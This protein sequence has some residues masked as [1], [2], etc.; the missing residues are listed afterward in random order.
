M[1]EQPK[2]GDLFGKDVVIRITSDPR[3]IT[4][5]ERSDPWYKKIFKYFTIDPI[6]DDLIGKLIV[7]AEVIQVHEYWSDCH[8]PGPKF[9]VGMQLILIEGYSRKGVWIIQDSRL[10]WFVLDMEKRT[11]EIYR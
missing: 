10:P 11:F 9:S 8:Y 2:L 6:E 7:S 5:Q 1:I 4:P 3:V